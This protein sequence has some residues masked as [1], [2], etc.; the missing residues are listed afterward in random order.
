MARQALPPPAAP[1]RLPGDYAS[2]LLLRKNPMA[3]VG[4][5]FAA[6]GGLFGF[7]GIGLCFVQPFLGALFL[8]F[9]FVFGGAGLAMRSGSRRTP[10]K[11]IAALTHGV[12]A[13]GHIVGVHRDGSQS[14][15]GQCPWRLEYVFQTASG[16]AS[17]ATTGWDAQHGL[18]RSGEEVW[19]VYLP[20][21]PSASSLWPP[22]S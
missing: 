10:S 8:L 18:R 3:I 20:Q 22:V 15:N 13:A 7:L 1:R 16:P 14:L 17:G 12:A 6:F 19:V 11:Q 4:S 5:A 9:G 21:D 2:N